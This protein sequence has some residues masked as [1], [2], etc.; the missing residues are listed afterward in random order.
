[1]M[2]KI[3]RILALAVAL[4]MVLSLPVFPARAADTQITL[5]NGDFEDGTTGWTLTGFSTVGADSYDTS[6]S[7]NT[8]SLWLSDSEALEGSAAYTV[9]LDAGTYYFTF[10]TEGVAGEAPLSYTVSGGSELVAATAVPANTGWANWQTVTT[11]SFTLTEQT[12]VTITISGTVPSG[13][14]GHLDN[15]KLYKEAVVT[16]DPISLSNGD[17]ETGTANNWSLTGF[18]EVTTD[19]WDSNNGTNALTLWLSDSEAGTGSAAYTVLLTKGEYYFTFD[20]DGAEGASPLSYTVTAGSA[21]VPAAALPANTGW[22][23]W[24][25]VETEK[26]T[27]TADTE[28]TITISGTLPAAWFGNLDNLKLFGTGALAEKDPAK[29]KGD[30]YVPYIKGTDGDFIRGADVSSLLSILNSGAAFKDWDGDPIDGQGFMNLLA[31]AGVNWI[32][33]R[34]WNDPFDAQGRGYGGGNNDLQAAITMGQW[35]TNAGMRVLIDFHYS[36]FWA[37]PGKQQVPKAWQGKSV[38][39]MA[40]AVKAYT[41]DSLAALKAAGVDVGMVQIGNETTNA[42]CGFSNWQDMCKIFSAG[43][44]AVREFDPAVLVAIHFTNPERSGNYANFARQLNNYNV[45]YDV[46][47]SSYYPYWHG[48]LANLT[49]VLKQVADTYGKQVLVAETSWAN[50]L[51][52]GDGHD[53]TVRT[54]NNDNDKDFPFCVQGQA[55]EVFSVAQAVRNVG[56]KGMGLFYWEAAWIP[57]QPYDKTAANA[58]EVLAQ[59]KALWEQH[60]SGWAS[61]YA[62]EY[63]A[64]DAGKWYGGSAVDNQAFFDFD[65]NPLE[66]LK[67][68]KYMQTGTYGY[69]IG[70]YEVKD[71]TLTYDAGESLRLP[72]TVDVVNTLGETD[73]VEVTW[74]ADD[75]AAVNM[76]KPGTYQVHGTADGKAVLCTVTV[77]AEN[78]LKNPSFEESDMSMYTISAQAT[79]SN[80]DDNALTGSYY[81]HFYN[82]SGVDFTAEQ[83]L[84]L[85][86][87]HYI[88]TVN[89]HGDGMGDEA[90]TY[91]YVRSGAARGAMNLTEAFTLSGWKVW[92]SPSIAF[93]VTEETVV[94]VGIRVKGAGGAWGAFDDW[95]LSPN[96]AAAHSGGTATCTAPAICEACGESYGDKNPDHHTGEAQWTKTETKHSKAYDC[97]GAEVVAEENHEWAGGK[98]GEC[99]YVCAHT[100]GT[101]TCTTLAVCQTCGESYGEKN[102][103]NHTG[104]A[105]WAQTE[106]KHSKAYD[107]CGAEVVAEE[108]HEWAGGKCGECGCECTH[109]GGTATCTAKAT[110]E[111]CGE[112]YGTALDHDWAD[113]TCTAP[114]TCKREGCGATEG[115]ALDHDWADATC[116][117]PKT[118]KRPGCGATLGSALEHTGGQ[119]TCKDKAVCDLC[120][121]PYGALLTTH[122]G[123]QATCK[124]KAVCDLCGEPY[125]ALLATHTGGAATCKDKAVCT[126][127]GNAYG[128]L[129]PRKHAGG[130]ELKGVVKAT[131]QKGGY[132]GDTYCIGCGELLE[133]GEETPRLTTPDTGDTFGLIPIMLLMALSVVGIGAVLA[134]KRKTY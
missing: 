63:D 107:C 47:A 127:C 9:T 69:T 49:S 106:T 34:V 114:R 91:I 126:L 113:A 131:T 101:A 27:L 108:N 111:T 28:V 83:T 43:A 82:G 58:T 79:R 2:M 6:N 48:S 115:E 52:D 104:E 122:T 30:I 39:E 89:G 85:Q 88:F 18:S 11:G 50:T 31:G 117:A 119:A 61:S 33:L 59:N 81:L 1:M 90:Q 8:L 3:R 134:F 102:G 56:E 65:G 5:P 60:G 13:W 42:I 128:E 120:G 14:W 16:Y 132:T 118:C 24:Q 78:L 51:D 35:A 97:C 74:D 116:K 36:D 133:K 20:V 40:S 4:V 64:E 32:R 75:A 46:F 73:Q 22:S 53:N 29:V 125:G 55:T 17:F 109:T 93:D 86:P 21:L 95:A 67:V 45:D 105:Q 94:T 87:G 98:C 68:F 57:V 38:D 110:C 12:P 23:N 54:G 112:S 124:D 37:D 129:D 7:T 96:A 70:V 15:L 77:K 19:Q 25:T 123:G 130:T 80:Q 99:D 72:A 10:D 41:A 76:N 66:S 26:F 121:E 84:T 44:E 103:E 92:A 71:A 62:A 100:G